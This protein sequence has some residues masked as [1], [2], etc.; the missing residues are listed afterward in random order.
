VSSQDPTDISAVLHDLAEPISAL[1]A[2]ADT[3]RRLRD[4]PGVLNVDELLSIL[5]DMG[6]DSSRALEMLRR[7]QH[8]LTQERP[9][10]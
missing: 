5:E 4:A 6:E 10:D 2:N 8:R 7:L 1:V 3:A 9:G